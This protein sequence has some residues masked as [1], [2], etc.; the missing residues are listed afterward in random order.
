[1]LEAIDAGI[2]GL[3]IPLNGCHLVVGH[4]SE[5]KDDVCAETRVHIL[6]HVVANPRTV[7]APIGKVTD[8]FG[9]CAWNGREIR[10]GPFPD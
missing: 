3:I 6:G 1:M 4:A 9:C 2:E 10:D 8:N 5:S 7:L